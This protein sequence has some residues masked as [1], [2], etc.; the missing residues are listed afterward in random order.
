MD[1]VNSYAALPDRFFCRVEPVSVRH[2]RLMLWNAELAEQLR[3]PGDLTEDPDRLAAVFSGNERLP[4]SDPLA[5]AY[6]GH[7]FGNF[8]PRLGDGRAHLIAE[9]CDVE[10]IGRDLQLKGSGPTPFSRGGDGRCALGPAL[11]EYIMSEA[12][13]AL[14]IPTTRCLAVVATGEPVM[15]ERVLPGAVVTRVASS[16]LRVGTFQYFAARGDE[17]GVRTLADYAIGRLYPDLQG[18]DDRYHALL[19]RVID[20][21]VRLVT[22]WM[23]VGFVHGVMN[24]DN[25]SISGETIDYGPCAM[26]SIYDPATVFSS[27][28]RWGRYAF[29]RQPAIIAWNMARLAETVLP[30]LDPDPARAT[31][32]AQALVSAMPERLENA[33]TAM[34]SRKLGLSGTPSRED[35]ALVAELC[36]RMRTNRMDYTITFDRLTRS[37]D[38]D[39]ALG[40]LRDEVGQDWVEAWSRRLGSADTEVRASMRRH[41]PVVI[42]RNHHVERVLAH[43]TETLDV[44]PVEAFLKVLRSPYALLPETA[45]YQDSPPDGDAGYVTFCGT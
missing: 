3:L 7:Q 25:T 28:D 11:R 17:A 15:R 42:P 20:A 12:M 2:P 40:R 39:D 8:V 4:G 5:M 14:G 10:G 32:R 38:S 23:R 16:H 31:Q 13:H 35:A 1:V 36:D 33:W 45:A 37:L 6:A 24:T 18:T 22:E 26:M 41:N 44:A 21:Q 29:G 19:E 34:M 43:A 30:M 27:I 9:L